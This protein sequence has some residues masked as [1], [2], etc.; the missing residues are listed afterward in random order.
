MIFLCITFHFVARL[1]RIVNMD[2]KTVSISLYLLLIYWL[3]LHF[4]MLKPLFYPTL[5]A[6]SYLFVSRNFE[7]KELLKLILGAG[8][9]S[10]I[11]SALFRSDAGMLAFLATA[12]LTI[13]LLRRYQLQAPP[14]LA[15]ALIPYFANPTSIWVVPV[16]VIASLSGLV[17]FLLLVETARISVTR[18]RYRLLRARVREQ[19]AA[20]L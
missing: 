15:V 12:L 14:I 4:P 3:S 19:R 18:Y 10:L 7:L 9:A 8:I 11:G 2:I 6:F 1:E 5:G 16:S 20:R 13:Q 17:V